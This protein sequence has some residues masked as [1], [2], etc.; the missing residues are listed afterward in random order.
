MWAK[1]LFDTKKT[2]ID[3]REVAIVFVFADEENKEWSKTNKQKRK[4]ACIV[5]L[6]YS[7]SLGN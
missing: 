7:C 1:P 4:Q 3:G 5:L 6:C 2:K